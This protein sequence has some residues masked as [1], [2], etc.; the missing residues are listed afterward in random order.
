MKKNF[1]KV[2]SSV[3]AMSMAATMMTACGSSSSDSKDA[4]A[5]TTKEGTTTSSTT[6]EEPTEISVM[7]WDRGSAAP[8]TSNE[9]NPLTKWIQDQVLKDCNVK[10]NYVAVPRSGSDDKL[11][12]MMAGGNA[13]D[14]VFTYS[15]GLFGDYTKN[16]GVADLTASLAAYGENITKTI[17]DIQYMGQYEKKQYAIM[18][19]RG[20]QIPRHISYIRKDWLD[21]LGMEVPKTKEDLIKYLY[22]V[23]EKNPGNV[24]KVIPWA[25][26]GSTDTE[27]FY[28]HFLE[29]YVPAKLS[30]KDA[31]IYSEN[32]IAFADG[33][34]NGLKELNKLYNDGIISPDFA[35]DTTTE[36]FK[37]DVSAGKVGFMLDDSTAYF[38]FAATLKAAVPNADF[39]PVNCFDL[40]DGSYRNPT[41]PLFGMYIMVPATSKD[42]TDAVVKYLNWLADPTNAENV[43]FTTDADRTAK[44]YPQN[45]ADYC[46]VNDHFAYVD[47]KDGMVSSWASGANAEWMT[48]DWATNLYD[49]VT[50]N[51]FLYPTAPVVLESETTYKANLDTA[52]IG[53]VYNLITCSPD[54]FDSVQQSEYKKLVDAGLEKVF[55][56]RAAYYDQNMAK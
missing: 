11:N 32:F 46:I 1:K 50:T 28:L 23:K 2:L 4:A 30:D 37:A 25:M 54:E 7:V 5:D 47:T 51:Q 8:G 56:E 26:G 9:D 35:V 15:A 40:D 43:S 39:V 52:A 45:S 49:V 31:Y 38:D 33:A 44:G 34:L 42:K 13:P 22:A 48:K 55:E 36:T 6:S 12:V 19:R 16:E 24:D 21:A 10:V 29:S 27:K 18:K 41:E 17:G 53:Y 14:V 3:L 20:F